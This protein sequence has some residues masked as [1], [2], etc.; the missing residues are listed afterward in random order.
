M[1][2]KKLRSPSYPTLALEAAVER[3]RKI[4]SA[5]STSAV[6]REAIARIM[7]YSSLSGA[8]L[9]ALAS[10]NSYGLLERRAKGEA[11]VTELAMRILFA[12]SPHELAQAAREA[13]LMPRVFSQ[14]AEK[15]EGHVPHK[16][17][18][19]SFL[20]R[21]GFTEKAAKVTARTYV[22]SI[23]FVSSLGDSD[24]SDPNASNAQNTPKSRS[25]EDL[26]STEGDEPMMGQG[27]T[28]GGFEF[29]ELLRVGVGGGRTVR[30][31]ADGKFDVSQWK[32]VMDQVQFQLDIAKEEAKSAAADAGEPS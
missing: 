7:D 10:L 8:S 6:D 5:Y 25:D 9:Q 26:R 20:R 17:G 32:R 19:I 29:K 14:I 30:V 21:N 4:Q 3:T 16:D 24:R 18:V 11:G 12:E 2:S 27:T 13:A 15:F 23:N 28:A 1:D 31:L 22:D